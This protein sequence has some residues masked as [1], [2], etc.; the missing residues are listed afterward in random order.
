MKDENKQ[1]TAT[2]SAIGDGITVKKNLKAMDRTELTDFMAELG[3]PAFRG[4]QIFA[5]MYRGAD[6]FDEMTDIKKD[7]RE[8]L[9]ERAYIGALTVL[10]RQVS[11]VDGTRKYLFGL[12]DGNAIETVFMKYKHGNSVCVSSQAGCR[13]GCKFC[14]SGLDGLARNLEPWEIADQILKAQRDGGGRVGNVVVM[15]TGEPF[16]NYDNL[17][18]FLKLVH[19]KDG[20]NLGYR[21]ITVST[22]GIVPG[23]KAF[24][25]QFPQVNLAI[26]LHASND[27]TRGLLMPVNSSYPMKELLSVCRDHGDKT[28]RRITFEYTLVSGVNDG[29]RQAEELASLLRGTLCH[30]NLIP[31][32]TVKE[33]DLRGSSREYAQR[34]QAALERRGIPAT[35]RRELGGDIDAACGQLRLE[36]TEKKE[37]NSDK[38]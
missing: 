33:H 20:L 3:E 4:K 28:G 26:S 12:E 8:K 14:A 37:G 18:A 2:A 35:V 32:N 9:K 22:C 16:D 27:K 29:E 11:A 17:S 31:L 1:E 6:S 24:G 7:L 5:W 36:S 25:R 10:K 19:E 34:F 23:I 38:N 13:M 21:S 15:G 30:V